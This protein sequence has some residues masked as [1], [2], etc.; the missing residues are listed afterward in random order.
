MFTKLGL[1]AGFAIVFA[2]S[3][4][5]RQTAAGADRPIS[6]PVQVTHAQNFRSVP[7]AGRQK[8]RLYLND[9]R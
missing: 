1:H 5:W 3:L 4:I 9:C 2:I 6:I 7:F 8:A